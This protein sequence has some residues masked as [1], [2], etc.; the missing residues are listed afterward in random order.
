MSLYPFEDGA[1]NKERG[2][3]IEKILS[4]RMQ[5]LSSEEFQDLLRPAFQEDE[6]T[7]I[8]VGGALGAMA[9]MFQLVVVFGI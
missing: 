6:W 8:F 7:L 9:G 2:L 3:I 4:D 1:L 5:Q